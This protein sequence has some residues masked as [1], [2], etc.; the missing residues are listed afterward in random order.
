MIYKE[1]EINEEGSLP[2]AKL[3]VYIQDLF[4]EISIKKRPLVLLC[5][6][7]GYS[8]TSSREAEPMAMAFMAKGY[9]TAIL[10]YSCYPA[11]YP[12][13]LLELGRAML[14][15]REHAQEWHV[16]TDAIVLEGCSAG[17]H[18]AANFAC[19]WRCDFLA[20]ELLGS[21]DEAEKE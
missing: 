17:G 19:T 7:G 16:D 5:P 2:G 20:K 13:S 6:G 18:L 4:N 1:Y 14:L 3:T 8:Y 21:T 11:H 15:I 10:R 9:S 12:T